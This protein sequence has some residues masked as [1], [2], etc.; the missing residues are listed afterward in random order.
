M[1]PTLIVIFIFTFL[2]SACAPATSSTQQPPT[3][4]MIDA[5]TQTTIP[6][7]TSLGGPGRRPTPG[8]GRLDVDGGK[9]VGPLRARI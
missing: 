8:A 5:V 1:K 9:C 6:T 4:D 7:A 2:F 3:Q